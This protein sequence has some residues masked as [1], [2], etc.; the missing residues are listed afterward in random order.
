[1][2]KTGAL[3]AH[4]PRSAEWS[5]D[6]SVASSVDLQDS[7]LLR[8]LRALIAVAARVDISNDLCP[9][10]SVTNRHYC[11]LILNGL[12]VSERGASVS[13]ARQSGITD[14]RVLVLGSQVMRA[15]SLGTAVE[16]VYL[17]PSM[18][19]I[20]QPVGLRAGGDIV[21]AADQRPPPERIA[22][23]V[24]AQP[25]TEAI[26]PSE[27]RPRRASAP[28]ASAISA[29]TSSMFAA[30]AEAAVKV[31]SLVAGPGSKRPDE[32][33]SSEAAAPVESG[34]VARARRRGSL[35]SNT[36]S[37]RVALPLGTPT[38]PQ[39]RYVATK[40]TVD[41]RLPGTIESSDEDS[42]DSDSFDDDDDH[43]AEVQQVNSS[44]LFS[45]V[46]PIDPNQ[47]QPISRWGIR[48][49]TTEP[50][51]VVAPTLVSPGTLQRASVD[52]NT[53]NARLPSGQSLKS[54][55]WAQTT[56]ITTKLG[57]DDDGE[58]VANDSA[59]RIA[60]RLAS[61]LGMRGFDDVG[62]EKVVDPTSAAVFACIP[63]A[64]EQWV[65]Q[66]RNF[67]VLFMDAVLLR[68][69]AE[70]FGC[71]AELQVT[72]P[73]RD[74]GRAAS[75]RRMRSSRRLPPAVSANLP[76][77][78]ARPPGSVATSPPPGRGPVI[79]VHAT[80]GSPTDSASLG[81]ERPGAPQSGELSASSG[82]GTAALLGVSVGRVAHSGG[83][84][85]PG[86]FQTQAGSRRSLPPIATLVA[87]RPSI[88]A[89]PPSYQHA[90]SQR[91]VIMAILFADIVGYSKMGEM[92]VLTFVERFLGSVAALLDAL[93]SMGL[94]SCA[95]KNTWGD[96][97][98]MV[99]SR[100]PDAGSFALLLS[101]LVQRVPWHKFG[102]PKS[103]SIRISL[104]AAPVHPVVDPITGKK[105]SLHPLRMCDWLVNRLVPQLLAGLFG[106]PHV[107]RCA[108]R[109]DH[110]SELV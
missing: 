17:T 41:V 13:L 33:T 87:D 29:K 84:C 26:G 72:G 45:L 7:N 105:A 100:V 69:T 6:S 9:E 101:D 53:R 91:Q 106:G 50:R 39:R 78:V 21:E 30:A 1:M 3:S 82:A 57:D 55:A 35:D 11:S 23:P 8:R 37:T 34:A 4:S 89:Q 71:A 74:L 18:L 96:G 77:G 48:R 75:V 58:N 51:A 104:H 24:V 61:A 94:R 54:R 56:A 68:T 40:A 70:E 97:L 98:Y 86:G 76:P 32:A 19:H 107:P 110:T 31:I 27:F 93:P 90:A 95:T 20:G 2:G 47:G 25:A 46:A 43:P 79:P 12:A 16:R 14:S 109:A 65:V 88:V 59:P 15:R 102:L 92:Q 108:H 10:T 28:P 62:P 42:D 103:L 66:Q 80:A 36:G 63:S 60:P 38:G 44:A 49:R 99:F 67:R 5:G 85:R 83:K 64:V 73:W 22:V 81:A 52:G